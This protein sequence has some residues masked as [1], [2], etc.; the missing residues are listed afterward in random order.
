MTS[1]ARVH[2][3]RDKD[4]QGLLAI[5]RANT[6]QYFDSA[7][8]SDFIEYLEVYGATYFVA[9]LNNQLIGGCGYHLEKDVLTGRISWSLINPSQQGLGVGSLLVNHCLMQLKMIERVTKIAVHTSQFGR[10][11]FSK[12]GFIESQFQKNYWGPGLDLY[13]M[14]RE[15]K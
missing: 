10:T 5:F 11:F 2:P 3:Y 14:E 8:E 13:L 12:F 4:L 6:P 1:P 15:A 7:E 9:H